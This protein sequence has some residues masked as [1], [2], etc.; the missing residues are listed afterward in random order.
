[1]CCYE[2]ETETFCNFPKDILWTYLGNFRCYFGKNI[3][4]LALGMGPN[5]G[6]LQTLKKSLEIEQEKVHIEKSA[7]L[8]A[9]ITLSQ[10]NET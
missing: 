9:N 3:S 7:P 1:M 10:Q 8:H 2:N 5:F 6:P 4:F